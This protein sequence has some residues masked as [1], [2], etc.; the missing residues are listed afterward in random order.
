MSRIPLV[1]LVLLT[2]CASASGPYSHL[3]NTLLATAEP[4]RVVPEYRLT[5]PD[6][7][8][9]RSVDYDAAIVGVASGENTSTVIRGRGV[10]T[11]YATERATGQEVILIYDDIQDR[12]FPTAILR[13]DRA[14]PAPRR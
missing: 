3:G 10:A 9:I 11:V 8:D 2:G 6:G 7:Y 12:P 5:V 14:A 1:T 4:G 13:L